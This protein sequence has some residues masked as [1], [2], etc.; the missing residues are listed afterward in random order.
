[1]YS[2]TIL[3]KIY[4]WEKEKGKD[5]DCELKQ[6]QYFQ[7]TNSTSYQVDEQVWPEQG[8]NLNV[9]VSL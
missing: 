2:S 1:M 9:T 3:K 6:P 7:M 8:R 5:E 4:D